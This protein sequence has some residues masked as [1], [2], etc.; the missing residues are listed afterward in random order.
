[1]NAAGLIVVLTGV[2]GAV[3]RSFFQ[4]LV[5]DGSISQDELDGT[6]KMLSEAVARLKQ[7][8]QEK[9]EALVA[10]YND[11]L[12]GYLDK[13]NAGFETETLGGFRNAQVMA[14]YVTTIMNKSGI[15]K[16]PNLELAL[17]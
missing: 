13:F 14:G 2:S 10:E 11:Q 15:S 5:T 7:T 4:N 16:V 17:E 6:R 9:I 3:G 12:S 1:M 8:P